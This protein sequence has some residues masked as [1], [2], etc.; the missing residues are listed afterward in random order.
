MPAGLGRDAATVT[1]PRAHKVK[2]VWHG[3]RNP[4]PEP[5]AR[6]RPLPSLIPPAHMPGGVDHKPKKAVRD[7]TAEARLT[8]ELI[9]E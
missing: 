2:K 5:T 7:F 8:P 4:T 1:C 3:P 6:H 9:S